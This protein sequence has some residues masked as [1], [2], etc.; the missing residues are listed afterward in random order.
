MGRSVCR[1]RNKYV[2]LWSV[3][4]LRYS[5]RTDARRIRRQSF[6]HCSI[7]FSNRFSFFCRRDYRWPPSRPLWA[8]T[9]GS[10]RC[11]IYGRRF[12]ANSASPVPCCWDSRLRTR[13]RLRYWLLSCPLKRC[14][15][16]LVR[17]AQDPCSGSQ[18]GWH[19]A[20][21]AHSRS[22]S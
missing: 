2:D 7:F 8:K 9:L 22:G 20:R 11:S 3:L 6:G 19:W 14:Y 5:A 17:K 10:S 18:H 13:G 1:L 16:C 21:Y 4:C 12:V 15:G